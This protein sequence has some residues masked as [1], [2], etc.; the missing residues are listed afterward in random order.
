MNHI[1][2]VNDSPYA[3]GTNSYVALGGVLVDFRDL[4][5]RGDSEAWFNAGTE[6]L[7]PTTVWLN[8]KTDAA[9]LE[10]VRLLSLLVHCT[11]ST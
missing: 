9:S 10:S 6:R 11:C 7:C 4:P 8:T 5:G 1:P 3:G 2:T